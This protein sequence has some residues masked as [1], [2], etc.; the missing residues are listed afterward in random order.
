MVINNFNPPKT[1]FA[2]L[3]HMAV[4]VLVGFALVRAVLFIR[5][6]PVID[7]TIFEWIYIFG[8]GFVYDIAFISYFCIP[9]VIFLL[10]LPNNWIGSIPFRF[11]A[12]VFGF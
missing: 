4:I 2:I 10:I 7:H 1:R 9:F 6:W 5:A 8:Q 11:L 3:F 12:Q